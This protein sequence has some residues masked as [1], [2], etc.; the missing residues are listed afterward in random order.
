MVPTPFRRSPTVWGLGP[1]GS[2][3]P[4]THLLTHYLPPHLLTHLPI[5][6]PTYTPAHSITNNRY[7]RV[8]GSDY[9][10]VVRDLTIFIFQGTE[11]FSNRLPAPSVNIR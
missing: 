6:P 5:H 9:G 10:R 11:P 8:D 2:Y 1:S 7:G 4:I 3:L